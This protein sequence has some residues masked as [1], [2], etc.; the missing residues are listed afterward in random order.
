MKCP[1]CGNEIDDFQLYDI[2]NNCGWENDPIQN[3][4]ENKRGGANI[5]S[6]K[7]FKKI[8]KLRKDFSLERVLEFAHDDSYNRDLKTI[9]LG[10]SAITN[11]KSSNV[12]ND[13]NF[14]FKMLNLGIRYFEITILKYK[15][16]DSRFYAY[17]GKNHIQSIDSVIKNIVAFSKSNNERAIIEVNFNIGYAKFGFKRL[18]DSEMAYVLSIITESGCFCKENHLDNFYDNLNESKYILII[19]NEESCKLA[20]DIKSALTVSN[21]CEL[22]LDLK[23]SLSSQLVK[24]VCIRNDFLILKLNINSDRRN[25]SIARP[26]V[27]MQLIALNYLLPRLTILSFNEYID[28]RMAIFTVIKEKS[29]IDTI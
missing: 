28:D 18:N 25:Q 1:C 14:L 17:I 15:L 13:D 9:I 12:I 19:K 10:L 23:N 26:Y 22:N 3:D 20:D 5:L 2:C 21:L 11:V 7:D 27:I 24:Y 4:D 8:I 29:I 16:D 6:L